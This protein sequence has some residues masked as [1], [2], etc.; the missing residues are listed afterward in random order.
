MSTTILRF[1]MLPAACCLLL[2]VPGSRVQGRSDEQKTG[3]D[4]MK[5]AEAAVKDE[6]PVL[7]K[8]GMPSLA[9]I[10]DEALTQTFP[11]QHFFGVTFR[12]YPVARAAPKPLK[13]KNIFALR[14]NGK[15][16]HLTDTAGLEEY[17]RE[18]LPPVSDEKSATDAAAAWLRLSE[19]FKQDG[20]FKFSI[21]R[22]SLK[23][24]K[25]DTGWRASGKAVVT[26]GGKGDISVSLTFTPAGKL[27]R[28]EEANS[29]KAGVRP[30]CQATK[31]LDA[32]PIVRRMAEKD[33]LVMGQTAKEYLDE[34][35]A[36]ASP[37]L[38]QAID[39]IWQRIVNEDW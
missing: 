7:R 15:T 24:E 16:R 31:L 23:A 9:R 34:Q 39:R 37:Q 1:M 26:Q 6:F 29:V 22:D 38:R 35:R 17:F 13:S 5:Q 36:L 20:Y 33:V 32:D 3:A 11:N 2:Y 21:P 14:K 10:T 30:I 12:Q 27:A 4:E 18:T 28:A 25:A 19:E 8:Q